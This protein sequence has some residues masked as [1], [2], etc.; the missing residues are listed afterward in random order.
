MA[1]VDH[2]RHV[3]VTGRP[4]EPICLRVYSCDCAMLHAW[5]QIMPSQVALWC[6]KHKT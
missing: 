6:R 4:G 1:A 2:V 3:L 5:H